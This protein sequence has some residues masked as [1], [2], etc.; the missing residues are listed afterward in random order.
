MCHRSSYTALDARHWEKFRR[1]DLPFANQ[2]LSI[3]SEIDLRLEFWSI[4]EKSLAFIVCKGMLQIPPSSTSPKRTG[5]CL[6]VT[7]NI[8]GYILTFRCVNCGNREV[9]A[10]YPSDNSVDEDEVRARTYQA[11]CNYCGWRGDACG[12]SAT[13]ISRII[14]LKARRARQEN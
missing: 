4:Q 11:S 10:T 8:P 14:E 2:R 12:H 6:M 3:F 1:N 9:F 7:G 5:V 13:H